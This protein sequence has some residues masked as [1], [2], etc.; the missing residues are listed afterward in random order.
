MYLPDEHGGPRNKSGSKLDF[1]LTVAAKA[2][3]WLQSESYHFTL[4]N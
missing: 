1:A 4:K 3:F 2:D